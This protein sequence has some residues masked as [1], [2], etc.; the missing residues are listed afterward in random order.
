MLFP[1]ICT[2]KDKKLVKLAI[3]VIALLVKSSINGRVH[4]QM[5]STIMVIIGMAVQIILSTP[6][7]KM[8]M[9]ASIEHARLEQ[10]IQHYVDVKHGTIIQKHGQM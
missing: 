3:D 6:A 7:E 9:N 4:V 5:L 2:E 10:E 8:N 1:H